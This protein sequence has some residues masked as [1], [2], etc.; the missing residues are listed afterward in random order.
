MATT[1]TTNT[2]DDTGDDDTGDKITR[3]DSKVE[4][5]QLLF[6][7]SVFDSKFVF[8]HRDVAGEFQL[9]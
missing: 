2:D 8:P 9:K 1:L 5:F 4:G 7:I 3:N 6:V